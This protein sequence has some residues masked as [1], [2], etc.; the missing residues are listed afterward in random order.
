[1]TFLIRTQRGITL[2]ELLAVLAI[3]SLI[4]TLIWSVFFQG[5][6][7]SKKAETK[8]RIQQEANI[9]VTNLIK[10][11]QS[12]DEYKVSSSNCVATVTFSDPAK[13]P[14]IFKDSQ[15]CYDVQLVDPKTKNVITEFVTPN[16]QDSELKGNIHDINDSTNKVDI[17]SLLYRLKGDGGS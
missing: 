5:F 4:G 12:S 8:N 3:L 15:L 16:T 7:F 1:M 13:S 14:L 17:D 9:L 2:V 11:H 10:I 6:N